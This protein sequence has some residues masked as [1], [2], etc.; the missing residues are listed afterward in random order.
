MKYDGGSWSDWTVDSSNNQV[1]YGSSIAVDDYGDVH[2]SYYDALN[3]DLKYAFF[4]GDNWTTTVI[5]G[6]GGENMGLFTSI[7]IDRGN[8]A[9]GIAYFDEDNNSLKYA[10]YDGTSW[11]H[12]TVLSGNVGHWISL[13]FD[14]TGRP[15]ITIPRKR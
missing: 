15:H 5:D 12:I 9:V 6:A 7:A 8:V 10:Q 13:T 14:S 1:G 11:E 3:K 2:I 4:D